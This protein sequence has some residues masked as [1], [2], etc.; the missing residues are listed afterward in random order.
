M[1]D[2][3]PVYFFQSGDT[4]RYAMSIDV[5][6]CNMP[7]VEQPW[8][9]R[10]EIRANRRNGP[11]F[12]LF[13]IRELKHAQ[14]SSHRT[15]TQQVRLGK[16]HHDA[17]QA[18]TIDLAPGRLPGEFSAYFIPSLIESPPTSASFSGVWEYSP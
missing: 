6:G 10:G 15:N 3:T 1:D 2:A 14:E 18:H 9:L 8:L 5:T 13:P 16:I 4:N 7:V 12:S 11:G 17:R